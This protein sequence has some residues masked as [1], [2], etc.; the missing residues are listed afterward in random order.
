MPLNARP[1]LLI[2]SVALAVSL[3]CNVLVLFAG[4][5]TL[6]VINSL[7]FLIIDATDPMSSSSASASLTVWGACLYPSPHLSGTPNCRPLSFATLFSQGLSLNP[8][9]TVPSS[10]FKS[11]SDLV[12]NLPHGNAWELVGLLVGSG[13][14]LL[15]L[16]GAIVAFA[17]KQGWAFLFC[18]VTAFLSLLGSLAALIL[19]MLTSG[20]E[21]KLVAGSVSGWTA[22]VGVP[23]T[24]LLAGACLGGI[25]GVVF[26]GRAGILGYRRNRRKGF[27][28][29]IDLQG[30]LPSFPKNGIDDADG[31][32]RG[33]G[34]RS[35]AD[36]LTDSSYSSAGNSIS[37]PTRPGTFAYSSRPTNTTPA[38]VYGA[39]NGDE[40]SPV[41]HGA[42][43]GYGG[44]DPH[45]QATG[46]GF[47]VSHSVDASGRLVSPVAPGANY[48]YV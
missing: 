10:G 17:S 27:R 6:S 39:Y 46:N 25:I 16:L 41:D 40:R 18:S 22:S 42:G 28:D 12:A 1:S 43:L 23:A 35:T 5:S 37:Y 30:N 21:S 8:T 15:S 9:L 4:L 2:G 44:A 36:P 24:A 47:L 48:K 19:A 38:V 11:A 32:R 45:V 13:F 20:A 29:S 26:S 3:I 34:Y 14:A 33:S 31:Q 7:G